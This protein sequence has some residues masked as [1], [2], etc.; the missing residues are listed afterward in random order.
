MNDLAKKI[1]DNRDRANGIF[2]GVWAC[3]TR[4]EQNRAEELR[5][6][7]LTEG[8]PDDEGIDRGPYLRELVRL[9]L[10]NT[11]ALVTWHDN[12]IAN[13]TPEYV[14]CLRMAAIDRGVSLPLPPTT[15]QLT[16]DWAVVL[17][18]VFV[19]A[20]RDSVQTTFDL[21]D[22]TRKLSEE[23]WQRLAASIADNEEID[24]VREVIVNLSNRCIG[25]YDEETHDARSNAIQTEA[26][27]ALLYHGAAEDPEEG[28]RNH[29]WIKRKSTNS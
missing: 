18:R 14:E 2:H 15:W 19:K 8:L 13:R 29:A 17:S 5:D 7:N 24:A 6:K 21:G 26:S 28:D 25:I 1:R 16:H 12:Y 3:S 10:S 22:D 27:A 23:N 11:G 9:V 4:L 20:A